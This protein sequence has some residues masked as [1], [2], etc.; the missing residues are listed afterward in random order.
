MSS[1]CKLL[2]VAHDHELVQSERCGDLEKCVLADYQAA[3]AG[4]LT[5][6]ALQIP[7]KPFGDHHGQDAVSKEFEPFVVGYAVFGL[8]GI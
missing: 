7:V 8:V 6:I 1:A 5:L 3:D 2:S 4:A